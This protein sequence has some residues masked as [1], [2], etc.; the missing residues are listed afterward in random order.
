MN[1][2]GLPRKKL[3][4]A[5]AVILGELVFILIPIGVAAFVVIQ[6]EGWKA[7]FASPEWAFA[8]VILAGQSG[9]KLLLGRSS[10][11]DR[12]KLWLLGTIMFAVAVVAILVLMSLLQHEECPPK[13]A[14]SWLVTMQLV[15]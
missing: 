7:M 8:A 12:S 2:N 3:M 10:A 6:K 11:L 13:A 9:A 4:S 5:M 15:L 14:E 1:G